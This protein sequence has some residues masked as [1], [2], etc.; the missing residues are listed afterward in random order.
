MKRKNKGADRVEYIF[1]IMP[2]LAVVLVASKLLGLL[3]WDWVFVLTPI[4][5][6]GIALTIFY[7]IVYRN[8]K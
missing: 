4:W 3:S 2:I 8:K 7:T 1:P 6:P 5:A